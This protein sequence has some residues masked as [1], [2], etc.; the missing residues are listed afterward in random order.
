MKILI[1]VGLIGLSLGAHGQVS[2]NLAIMAPVERL[3]KGMNLGDSAMVHSA[4]TKEVTM[5]TIM[6]DKTGKQIVRRESSLAGFL[7]AVGTPHVEPW[8]EPIWDTKIEVDGTFAQVW[9]QYAFYKGKMCNLGAVIDNLKLSKQSPIKPPHFSNYCQANPRIKP[10]TA[11]KNHVMAQI[12]VKYR[13]YRK[14]H[15]VTQHT[16]PKRRARRLRTRHP[17]R[18]LLLVHRDRTV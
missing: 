16:H 2:E 8:S 11:H 4:F 1:L 12:H 9:A 13:F 5:A 3:F 10:R 17:R 6:K 14:A 7:K 15:H 18:R